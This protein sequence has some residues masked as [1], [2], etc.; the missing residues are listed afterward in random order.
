MHWFRFR[1]K[2][3]DGR[4]PIKVSA[5]VGISYLPSYLAQRIT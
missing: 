4:E 5:G 1:A 3:F 2:R